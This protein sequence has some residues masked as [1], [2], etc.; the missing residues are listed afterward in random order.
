MMKRFAIVG[1]S[2][3][4]SLFLVE[5]GLLRW[6]DPWGANAYYNDLDTLKTHYVADSERGY[7]LPTGIYQL[8]HWSLTI[9]STGRLVPD[10]TPD[11]PIIAL[12]GDSLTMGHG[13]NDSDTFANQLARRFPNCTFRDYGLNGYNTAQVQATIDNTIA[14]HY[15]YTLVSNDA[16]PALTIDQM[17]TAGDD[18]WAG[19]HRYWYH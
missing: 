14:A 11:N 13:V 1:L 4:M 7:T 15:V 9:T 12:V 10:T 3:F 5:Y 18:F 19:L 17:Y 6:V 2:I 16:E 8:G